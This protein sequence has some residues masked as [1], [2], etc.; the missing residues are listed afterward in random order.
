VDSGQIAITNEGYFGAEENIYPKYLTKKGTIGENWYLMCCDINKSAKGGKLTNGMV[1]GT[2]G[3]GYFP[4]R[5][6][7]SNG[8]VIGIK[9]MI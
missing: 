8:K 7:K 5:L 3:D 4:F 1:F 9:I 6:A 2:A